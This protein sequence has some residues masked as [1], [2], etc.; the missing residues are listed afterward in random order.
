MSITKKV[1]L[2]NGAVYP[3]VKK[4]CSTFYLDYQLTVG[5]LNNG[6]SPEKCIDP[7]SFPD[8][9]KHTKDYSKTSRYSTE[10]LEKKRIGYHARWIMRA[11]KKHGEKFCYKNT[12]SDFKTAKKSK[13][14]I[15]CLEHSHPFHIIPD[16]H[17]LLKNGGCELCWKEQV[18]GDSLKRAEPKFLAWFNKSLAERLELRSKFRGWRAPIDLYCKT[19]KTTHKT[20]NPN[21]LKYGG[22]LGCDT[23]SNEALKKAIRLD[24]KSVLEKVKEVR[25]LPKN[26]TLLDIIFDEEADGSRIS[27]S[28]ALDNH[29]IRPQRVD[30]SH[31][32]KS[33]LICDLCTSSGGGTAETRY[34]RL[35]ENNE[36]GKPAIIGVME[37]EAHGTTGMKLGVTTRTLQKRYGYSLKTIFFSLTAQEIDIYFI[38]NRVKRRFAKFRDNI[39]LGKGLRAQLIGGKRWGG[40]TEIFQKNKQQEIIDY[41]IDLSKDIESAKVDDAEFG[42]E[43]DHWLSIDFEARDV[44]REKDISNKPVPVVGIDPKTNE[45]LF[46]LDA[47]SEAE[48]LGFWNVRSIIHDTEG[49]QM[50]GGLRWF[51]ASEFDS[52]NIPPLPDRKIHNQ[53]LVRC[54]ETGEVFKTTA[55]AEK[56]MRSPEHKVSASQITSVCRGHR[57]KAGGYSWEYANEEQ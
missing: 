32:K 55:E 52:G 20:T 30:L 39:I 13:V 42:E 41:I 21:N 26:I 53:K 4:F 43:L 46:K 5:R 40:D 14:K 34:R 25:E 6:W 44:S 8:Y 23:C 29:G 54:I 28:C 3:S 2:Q 11:T 38:E 7:K 35:I 18:T 10:A 45:I 12:L 9:R 17:A 24:L 19:H 15:K 31:L 49:R 33:P 36:K 57:A 51:K 47:A 48:N 16:K 37:I 56:K 1:K 27:Y 50:S 22:A